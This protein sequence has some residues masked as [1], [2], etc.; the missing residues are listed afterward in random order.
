MTDALR[1]ADFLHG[2]DEHGLVCA[3]RF[4]PGRAAEPLEAAAAAQWLQAPPAQGFLWLHVNLAHTGAEPWLR[5]RAG[6]DDAFF[7]ALARGSPSTRIERERDALFAVFNDVTFD[8]AF[9]AGDVATLWVHAGARLVVSARRHRLRAVDRLRIAVR[10][11]ERID[12]PVGLLDHLLR[13]QADELQRIARSAVERVDDIEDAML[14]GKHG[15]G[16]MELPRLRRLAVRLQRLLALE[17]GALLRLLGNPPAWMGAADIE[18]LRQASE[19]FAVVLRDLSAMQERIKL[20]QDEAAARVAEQNNR[21]LFVLTMVTVLAL[22]INL[23]AGLF[24]MNVGGV[25]LAEAAHGFWWVVL[26]VAGATGFVAW[27]LV[28]RLPARR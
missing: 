19:D 11:G 10:R 26:G 28:K 4:E 27:R 8:F 23:V 13:D 1:A 17:P 24:G 25:P 12:G 5:T 14:A 15:G 9:E 16:A 3:Y 18:R 2:A 21:S 6:L 22:P 20:L 7:E